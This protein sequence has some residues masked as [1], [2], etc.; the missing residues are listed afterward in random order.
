MPGTLGIIAGGGPMPARLAAAVAATGRPVFVLGLE[1]HVDRAA[2]ASFPH[3]V[4]RLGAAGE[5]L[6]A[7]RG[8]G[9]DEIVLIG[10]VKRPSLLTLMPDSEGAK[11]LARIGRAAFA[12]DDGLLA[13][14]IR[15]LEE[16]GFRVRGVQEVMAG[17]TAPE[18][19]LGR[20]SPTPEAEA[21]IRRGVAV[22]RALGAVDVGQ[23]VVVQQGIVLAVEAAE[24]T[25]ALLARSA[26][27]RRAGPPGVLV[28]LAKPG[29][30]A[31]ADLPTIGVR[32]VEGAARAGLAG[33]AIEAGLTLLPERE[34]TIAAA[35]ELALFLVARRFG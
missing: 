12:G 32:T 19:V 20:V 3:R 13:A 6:A 11:I 22:A 24:G 35:D 1:G 31:R 9:V 5:A 16:E 18:G 17:L 7:L 21:D 28:K 27:L 26:S 15:V 10:P 4:V 2:V 33:I 29:Q 14:V 23:A 25:D 30:E 8:A 34:A